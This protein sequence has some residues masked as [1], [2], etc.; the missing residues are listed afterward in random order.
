MTALQGLA[1]LAAD[2]GTEVIVLISKPPAPDVAS[3]MLG[4]VQRI[5]KPV[6][7]NFVGASVPAATSA[8]VARTLEDAAQQAVTLATGEAPHWPHWEALPAQEAGRLASTQK[9]VRGLYSGGT[10][11]Y[12][13]LLLLPRYV[14]P[15]YSNT[16]LDPS[17]ALESALRSRDHSVID[18]GSDELTVGRLHPMLDPD[19]RSQRLAREADDPE[20]AVILLDVVL[21]FGAH[22]DPARELAETIR[23]ARGRAQAAGRWLPVVVSVCGTDEDPQD[24]EAQVATLIDAGAIVQVSNARAVRLAGLIA[25][26]AGNRGQSSPLVELPAPSPSPP[27]PEVSRIL[28]LLQGPRVINVGLESFAESLASQGVEVV[29]VDWQPPAGG[30][31]NLIDILDKLNA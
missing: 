1:A 15:V 20:V 16:P 30:K 11:C 4:A 28:Q 14:G 2:P 31:Q 24:Y 17:Y 29:P 22:P 6:V 5:S 3:H 21:G 26:A 7:I 23:K 10:L 18:M 19:L 25:E 27:L 13:A 12:E 9:Y 8:H